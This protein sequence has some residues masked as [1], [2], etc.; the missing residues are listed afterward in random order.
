ML[1]PDEI[2]K[3]FPI[4]SREINGQRLVYLDSAATSQKP[5]V[6][7]DTI[8]A[9]YQTINANVH[10][11]VYTLS[12]EATAAYESARKKVADFVSAKKEEIVFV[13]NATEAINLVAYAWGRANINKGDEIVITE[14]EHHSNIVPWQILSVEKDAKL[15]IWPVEDDGTLNLENLENLITPQTKFV[16]LSHVSNVLGTINDIEGIIKKIK[17]I[18]PQIVVI[19]DGAQAVPHLKVNVNHLGAD[20]YVFTGHKMLGPMGLGILWGRQEILDNMQPFLGG[21]EMIREVTWAKTTYNDLPW[22]FEAGTPNVEGAIGLGAAI[23]YLNQVGMDEIRDHE[24]KLIKYAMD[25][26][27]GDDQ[28]KIYGPTDIEKKAGVIS[29]NLEKVHAHDLA[30]VADSLGIAIRSGH[31]CAQ[32]LIKSLGEQ[33]SARASFYLYNTE[34]DVDALIAA[35]TKAKE[36]FKV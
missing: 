34:G 21:G 12:E 3:D 32:P 28:I 5:Q 19:V 7:I 23:D 11:G 16:A 25:K 22:K 26:L 24:K 14:M 6:V 27:S 33:A 13:R 15:V 1:N 8:A 10:R 18:N 2:K 9:Y 29:F 31:H 20:F 36:V 35:I 4:L 30:A 17:G